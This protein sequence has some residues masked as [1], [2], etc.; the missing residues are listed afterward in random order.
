MIHYNE[1]DQEI[2]RTIL[3]EH[4][5]YKLETYT[6]TEGFKTGGYGHRILDGEDIPT[7]KEGWEKVFHKDFFKAVDGA[8]ALIT[9]DTVSP[10]AFGIVVE[11]CYQM[12]EYGVSRFK[13]FLSEL[14]KEE[15]SYEEASLQMLDSK[16]AKQQTPRRAKE[17][18]H[19]MSMIGTFVG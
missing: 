9:V 4:E 15:P 7:T 14:N 16:W 10:A 19:R 6:C 18:A 1:I 13:M 8:S 3:K 11:M 2:T 17:M 5:G 12:G